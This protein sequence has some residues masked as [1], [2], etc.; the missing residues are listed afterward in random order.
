M[1]NDKKNHI[2]KTRHLLVGVEGDGVAA[3]LLAV[4]FRELSG[5]L[6]AR[7]IG[8]VLESMLQI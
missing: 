1:Q 8:A 4:L 6:L 2:T 3:G 5:E 7:I